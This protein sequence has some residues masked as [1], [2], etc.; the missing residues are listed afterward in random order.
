MYKSDGTP[1]RDPQAFVAAIKNK[2]STYE[3]GLVDAHGVEIEDPVAFAETLGQKRPS[4]RSSEWVKKED[5]LLRKADGT[6]VRDP[7]AFIAA[8]QRRGGTYEGDLV[9]AEGEE[10]KDLDAFLQSRGE[11]LKAVCSTSSKRGFFK[12]DGTAVRDP[13][14]FIAAI[15]RRGGTY[16]GGLFN[17]R[18]MEIRDPAAYLAGMNSPDEDKRGSASS[19][20]RLDGQLYKADGTLI[21]KPAAFLAGIKKNGGY[22]GGLFN[23][24]GEEVRD[25]EA[26]IANMDGGNWWRQTSAGSGITV[27]KADGTLVRDPN[28]FVAGIHKGGG[29]YRGG[30]FD[31]NGVEI[32]DPVAYLQ[33]RSYWSRVSSSSSR[34]QSDV[35]YKADGKVV[36]NPVA[37]VEGMKRSGGYQGG[38]FN[39]KG[40]EIRDADAYIKSMQRPW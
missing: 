12:A 29:T 17:E 24:K 5:V 2:V 1:I 19:K 35:L 8:I 9:D 30:L 40:V 22:Q 33:G 15:T 16:Q 18:G 34:G 25:A 36:H 39:S 4:A 31:A 38:L 28:A 23:S 20:G 26:Y 13:A 11:D 3:G 21:K 10:V 7:A 27:Y 37:Y 6:P 32:R 14:A